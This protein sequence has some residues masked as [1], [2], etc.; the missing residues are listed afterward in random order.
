MS[1]TFSTPNFHSS[2]AVIKPHHN[3]IADVLEFD[4]AEWSRDD[5][6]QWCLGNQQGHL[7]AQVMFVNL[8]DGFALLALSYDK[9]IVSPFNLNGGLAFNLVRDI[10]LLR[11]NRNVDFFSYG[12]NSI[13]RYSNGFKYAKVEETT[14]LLLSDDGSSPSS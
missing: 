5:V 12:Y 9:L 2:P 10:E 13:E 4:V 8:I 6:Y 14:P 7:Y 3:N 11:E 1:S